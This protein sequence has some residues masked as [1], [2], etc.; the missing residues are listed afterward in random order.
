MY[1]L[2]CT[3]HVIRGRDNLLLLCY[4]AVNDQYYAIMHLNFMYQY[5][6]KPTTVWRKF[7][8]VEN[9]DESGLGKV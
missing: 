3:H 8:T 9:F 7:L 4:A 6:Q 1:S 2:S 5:L